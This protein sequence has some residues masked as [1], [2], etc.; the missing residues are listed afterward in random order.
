MK[1]TD[2]ARP[3]EPGATAHRARRTRQKA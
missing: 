1:K 2:R 3:D